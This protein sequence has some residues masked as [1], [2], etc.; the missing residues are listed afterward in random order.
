MCSGDCHKFC[1]LGSS[2][3]CVLGHI[4]VRNL[5]VQEFCMEALLGAEGDMEPYLP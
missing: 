1:K 5:K 4:N 2:N 3:D